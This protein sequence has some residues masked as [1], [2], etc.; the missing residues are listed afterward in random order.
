MNDFTKEELEETLCCI[1]AVRS[2]STISEMNLGELAEKL[3]YM[4]AKY[5]DHSESKTNHN[6]EVE[7]CKTC[8]HKFVG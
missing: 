8:S 1:Q 4:I 7:E 3:E 2:S 6:Y 5:C